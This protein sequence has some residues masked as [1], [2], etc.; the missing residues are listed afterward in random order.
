MKTFLI[1]YKH[2]VT[3]QVMAEYLLQAFKKAGDH[4]NVIKIEQLD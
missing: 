2:G 3:K 1:T 4:Y